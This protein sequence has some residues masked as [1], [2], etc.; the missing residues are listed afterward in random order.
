MGLT[1]IIL[2]YN[3]HQHVARC[4]ESI[5]EI[6]DRIVVV[7]SGSLDNTRDVAKGLGAEVLNNSWLNYATQFNWALSQLDPETEWVLRI[8]ADEYLTQELATDIQLRLPELGPEIEGVYLERRMTFQGRLIQHGGVFPGK[9]LRLFRYGRGECENRWM[10]EHIKVA[11]P[12]V[13]F[14]G[15][16]IDDN[17]NSLTWWTDKHNK[18][19]SR[20]AVD[21]LNLEYGFMPHDSVA[22]LQGGGQAGVKRWLKERVYARLPTGF[23]AFAYFFYRYAIRLGFLDGQAGTAFHFLQGFWYRYLVDAKVLEVKRYM[24]EH[25]VDVADAIEQVLDIKV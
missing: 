17:L 8:D 19:A 21:I 2:T 23:R 9:M 4:I 20:E 15:E 6:S 16:L 1:A 12:T 24:R 5:R 3:E 7:D 11:G 18:Y 10:D 22:S 13:E 25:Q 14:K